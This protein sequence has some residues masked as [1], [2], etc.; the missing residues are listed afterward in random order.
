MTGKNDRLVPFIILLCFGL[1]APK[2]ATTADHPSPQSAGENDAKIWY[3]GHSGW[4]VRTRN[5]L[6]IFDYEGN[7]L[8]VTDPVRAF[9]GESRRLWVFVSHDHRDHF[10]PDIFDWDKVNRKA[11][12][13]FGWNVRP[14]PHVIGLRPRETRRIEGLEILTIQST[15]L[16][17][18]F[19][20][21]ADGLVIFHAGDFENGEGLWESYVREVAF[22][23]ANTDRLDMAFIPV[24]RNKAD[25]WTHS[26]KGSFHLIKTLA[27]NV[28]FPMHALGQETYYLEFA[29]EAAK[30]NLRTTIHCAEKPGDSFLFSKG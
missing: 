21:K 8:K 7:G 28:V 30:N 2:P 4:A 13:I 5:H 19:L 16:G 11:V 14:E 26:N 23:K 25:W 20:V 1:A 22:L 15:D 29:K 18:G 10:A 6:L 17:V 27:P 3:L 9:G 24:A 12:Y